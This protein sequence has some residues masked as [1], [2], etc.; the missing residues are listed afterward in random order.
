MTGRYR[1]IYPC[2]KA[3]KNHPFPSRLIG[4]NRAESVLAVKGPLRRFAPLTAPVRSEKRA[5]YEGKGEKRITQLLCIS[6]DSVR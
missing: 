3:Q 1:L 5:A 2:G 4:P 6:F